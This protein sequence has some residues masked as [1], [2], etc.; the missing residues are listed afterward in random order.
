MAL[1]KRTVL[2]RRIIAIS[3]LLFGI[4]HFVI[5]LVALD[6]PSDPLEKPFEIAIP[7]ICL[8]AGAALTIAGLDLLTCRRRWRLATVLGSLLSLSLIG[9]GASVLDALAVIDVLI[10]V[11]LARVW[12]GDWDNGHLE[13]RPARGG[14]PS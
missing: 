4:A 14:R 1:L 6:T 10:L 13:D 11:G 7:A 5:A 2:M 8:A 3:F 12:I 9:A